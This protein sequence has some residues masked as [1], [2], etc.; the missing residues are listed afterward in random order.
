MEK[1]LNQ[2]CPFFYAAALNYITNNSSKSLSDWVDS[3]GN[4]DISEIN[5]IVNT[6]K[7]EIEIS[8]KFDN[9]KINQQNVEIEIEDL[10]KVLEE[11][12]KIDF[13]NIKREDLY[14]VQENFMSLW[15]RA[16][17]EKMDKVIAKATDELKQDGASEN[18][19]DG[20]N[21]ILTILNYKAYG[22][23]IPEEL[24]KNAEIQKI[25]EIFNEM[26]EQEQ[27]DFAFEIYTTMLEQLKQMQVDQLAK[28]KEE[29]LIVDRINQFQEPYKNVVL[30][31]F[32]VQTVEEF[33]QLITSDDKKE[34][35]SAQIQNKKNI[36]QML[37]ENTALIDIEMKRAKDFSQM[38]D[39]IEEEINLEDL[40][41]P[42]DDELESLKEIQSDLP[43]Y[44]IVH[45]EA[46]STDGQLEEQ[47][48]QIKKVIEPK[49][50]ERKYEQQDGNYEVPT[51]EEKTG[52]VGIF[53]SIANSRVGRAVKNLFKS[54][55]AQKRLDAPA[56]QRTEDGLKITEYESNGS[57]M[58]TTIQA[59]N[60]LR[61]FAVNTV[62]A[63][64]NFANNISNAMRGN[65]EAEVIN[66]PTI[67]KS[68]SVQENDKLQI[69]DQAQEKAE[70]YMDSNK[71]A[72]S[73][74]ALEAQAQKNTIQA[75]NLQNKTQ[76]Q[77]KDTN[78]GIE[79]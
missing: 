78:E 28:S 52:I 60:F 23:S 10:K 35:I 8:N 6:V 55:D 63:V 30:K 2:K 42:L 73:K 4:V 27:K 51:F 66:K 15:G 53:A 47:V 45:E 13:D 67:I 3:T 58:P 39:W 17:K 12:D 11:F 14:F 22:E 7:K 56:T 38:E 5:I 9:A 32:K 68:E 20:F 74:E 19:V 16:D 29:Q 70:T 48:D 71:W 24:Q 34:T 31:V 49:L 36:E 37:K 77:N 76:E 75:T 65:K 18:L 41:L 79:Y 54:K 44:D 59:R 61:D 64:T 43:E 26:S 57:L 50:E 33:S 40:D 72:V 21:Q 25:N 69:V 1:E 46:L 62:E